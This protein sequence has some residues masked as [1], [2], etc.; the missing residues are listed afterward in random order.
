MKKQVNIQLEN[1]VLND[2]DHILS[3]DVQ[4]SSKTHFVEVAVHD[5][6]IRYKL[7]KKEVK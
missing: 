1:D 5:F 2:I 4:F 6:L 3:K 7:R